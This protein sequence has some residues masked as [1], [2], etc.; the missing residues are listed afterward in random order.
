[1]YKT[2]EH[3]ERTLTFEEYLLWSEL[4]SGR[5]SPSVLQIP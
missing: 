1:M 3:A 2:A 4:R 5:S